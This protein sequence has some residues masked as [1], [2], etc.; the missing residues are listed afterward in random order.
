MKA[1]GLWLM[2]NRGNIN[3]RSENYMGAKQRE[4]EEMY[5]KQGKSAVW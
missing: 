4:K 5:I 2:S 1:C 3:Q